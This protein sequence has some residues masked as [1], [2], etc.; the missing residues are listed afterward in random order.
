LKGNQVGAIEMDI[1]TGLPLK[2]ELN[3]TIN[4]KIKMQDKEI[5][6]DMVNNTLSTLQNK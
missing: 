4:G 6:L 3:Q 2:S 5:L 1:K